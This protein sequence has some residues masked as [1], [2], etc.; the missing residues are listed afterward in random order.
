M[1][2]KVK[3]RKFEEKD[4]VNKVRWINDDENNQFL[5]Y[6]LPLEVEKTQVWFKNNQNRT[7]RYDA[8][9]E[10]QGI[11]VGVIGLLE[12][13]DGKAEYYVTLGENEFKGRGI[14]KQAT[15]LLLE[16]AFT[17]L[18]IKEVYLYTEVG[19]LSAQALFE[20]S[21][22]IKRGVEKNSVMNRGKY[23]DRYYYSITVSDF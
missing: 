12:I 13:A 20:K 9:I 19:N 5:H 21:G 15:M 10:Y 14:A 11:P 7:D 4:I 8:V 18:K 2:K 1:Q 16:Y 3:I 6:D 17:V 23:V 22:F